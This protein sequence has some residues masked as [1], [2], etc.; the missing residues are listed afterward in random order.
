MSLGAGESREIGLL[1][2]ASDLAYWDV[3]AQKFV[4]EPDKI[5]VVIG[6]A[7]DD[8]KLETTVRVGP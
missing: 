6:G 8:G 1:V 5:K 4:V 3:S 2:E 7:S